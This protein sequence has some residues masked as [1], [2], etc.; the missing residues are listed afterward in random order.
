[1]VSPPSR[2][3][4]VLVVVLV[5]LPGVLQK[6]IFDEVQTQ[7]RVVRAAPTDPISPPNVHPLNTNPPGRRASVT[8]RRNLRNMA[9]PT[10][11][12]PQPIRIRTWSPAES[13]SLSEAEKERMEAAVEEA[14]RK[15][16][17]LLSV[18]RVAGP[19]LLSRDVNK[20]CKFLWRNSSTANYNRCGRANKSYRSET[21]LDVT[22]PDD[23]LAGCDISAEAESPLRTELRPEGAGLPDTDFLLY[24][25]L[26]ATDRCRAEPS[27][28]AYAV[29]CQTDAD[30]RPVAG[31]VVLCRDRLT[32]ATY[33]HQATVQTVIHELL[34]ALGFS[35]DLFH[36][37]T[38]CS[39]KSQGSAVCSPRGKVTHSDGSGQVRIYTPSVISALQRLLGSADP[40]LGG[41]LENLDVPLGKASSHWE[42]RVLQGSI[43]AA[44]LE[45]PPAVRIDPVTLAALQDTGWYTVDMSRAQSLVWGE[46]EGPMFG[47]LSTCQN[48]SS[49]FFCTGSGSGC[50]YLHLHK[51]ECQTDRYLEGCRVY[52]P[53]KNGSECWKEENGGEED[54]SGEMFGFHSRCFFSNL[55]R[56]N[57]SEV[58]SSGSSE[59]G[60]CYRHRCRGPNRYQV[61]VSGSEWE[62][63]PAGDTVKIK[64]YLGSVH[65]PD[66][67]LCRY[68][69]IT[70][71]SNDVTTF[72]ASATSDPYEA[73][74]SAQDWSW[75]P[76]RPPAE[77]TAASALCL[78]AAVCVLS[79]AVVCYRKC[80]A[81]RVRI[82]AA[83][84]HHSDL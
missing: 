50:H 82:H 63:C 27:V 52:K 71:P 22:I 15:V 12:S 70:P 33:S 72:P 57:Q 81:C 84:E 19:L 42:A 39:S 14:V 9:P 16:S 60:R 34:H 6:C 65:C 69:D 75:P 29:H 66:G 80:C 78:T 11:A 30:G 26:Q 35:K 38:D 46:G 64:G 5:E 68:D 8:H 4:W 25:L 10:P 48:K 17:S 31:V 23:H 2:R 13:H 32:G 54:W 36:T 76:L 55:T 56:Q 47:S 40:E 77:L 79:A 73:V 43:M 45:D 44:V 3:L 58:P 83:S 24:L 67:R 7:A 41:A 59:E 61:Q 62:D 21:C 1:M 74:P 18:I 20:Y 37:W 51:G 28:L 53:L 49:S